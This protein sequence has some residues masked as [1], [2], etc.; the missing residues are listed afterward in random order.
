MNE[1]PH[2]CNGCGA[3]GAGKLRTWKTPPH[4]KTGKRSNRTAIDPPESWGIRWVSSVKLNFCAVCR[5]RLA[6]GQLRLDG[7]KVID[8]QAER[9]ASRAA[10][11]SAAEKEAS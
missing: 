2:K 6:K 7:T 11:R 9:K 3:D 1:V 10:R 8:K 4:P 5:I